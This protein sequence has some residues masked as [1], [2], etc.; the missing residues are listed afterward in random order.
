MSNPAGKGNTL[1]ELADQPPVSLGNKQ[2]TNRSSGFDLAFARMRSRRIGGAFVQDDVPL[3]VL[4]VVPKGN[5]PRSTPD[6]RFVSPGSAQHIAAQL[7]GDDGQKEIERDRELLE[8]LQREDEEQRRREE[9]EQ[10]TAVE[11]EEAEE[12]RK[13][14]EAESLAQARTA[15]WEAEFYQIA[16]RAPPTAEETERRD[17]LVA[18]GLTLGIPENFLEGCNF[19]DEVEELIAFR[20]QFDDI[21]VDKL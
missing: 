15:A 8:R 7:V 3:H 16:G 5:Y 14:E 6:E 12:R 11:Q 13:R 10:K 19:P 1:L 9:E 18:K 20:K 17:L 4:D 2:V 21:D